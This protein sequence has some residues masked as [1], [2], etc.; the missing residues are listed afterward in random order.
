MRASLDEQRRQFPQIAEDRADIGV[1]GVGLS[2]VVRNPGTEPLGSEEWVDLLLRGEC[3]AR[4]RQIHIGR[5]QVPAGWQRHAGVPQSQ[6]QRHCQPGSRRLAGESDLTGSDALREQPFVCGPSVLDRGRKGVLGSQS[7]LERDGLDASPSNQITDERDGRRRVADDV[8]AAVE[9][10][11]H[12]LGVVAL[13]GDVDPTDTADLNWILLDVGRHRHACHELA[14]RR[15]QCRNIRAGVES[16]LAKDGVQ[17]ELLLSAHELTVTGTQVSC[18][19]RMMVIPGPDRLPDLAQFDKLE[20]ERFDLGKH[21]EHGGPILERAGEYGLAALQLRHHRRERG[22]SGSSEPA[23]YPDRVQARHHSHETIMPA[24]L[25]SPRRRN[26]V[27]ELAADR[28]ISARLA[29]AG[30]RAA[31]ARGPAEPRPSDHPHRAWRTCC[32]CAC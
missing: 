20:A 7:V 13:G 26:P 22:Q 5:H 1:S 16:A 3:L 9:V 30:L 4:Q 2:D 31:A 24:E 14:E 21:A 11:D 17:L 19:R 25:V 10:E 27:I 32:G 28:T 18:R 15:S 12:I 6:Q 29:R 8:D 23:L